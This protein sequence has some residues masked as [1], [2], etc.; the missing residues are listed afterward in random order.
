MAESAQL[1]Q[2]YQEWLQIPE[3]RLPPNHYALLG[4]DDYVDDVESI[5]QAAKERN[6]YLHQLAAGP[7]RKIVQEMLGKIAIAR[8]T[9]INA[10]AKA[11]YDQ[12]LLNPAA[13]VAILESFDYIETEPPP[14]AQDEFQDD[15]QDDAPERPSAAERMAAGRRRRARN[16]WIYHAISASV[17]LA[18]VGVIYL[19]NQGGGRRLV[20][21]QKEST[22]SGSPTSNDSN[23]PKRVAARALTSSDPRPAKARSTRPVKPRKTNSGLGMGLSGDMSQVFA[24]INSANGEGEP[25][26]AKPAESVKPVSRD[27]IDQVKTNMNPG[28]ILGMAKPV[29]SLPKALHGEFSSNQGKDWFKVVEGKVTV[30]HRAEKRYIRLTAKGKPFAFGKIVAVTSS[31]VPGAGGDAQV[32]VMAGGVR[33]GLRARGEQLEVFAKPAKQEVKPVVL[34]SIDKKAIGD[35]ADKATIALV[36]DLKDANRFHWI[37]RIGNSMENGAIAVGGVSGQADTSVFV[38]APSKKLDAAF[39]VKA[40]GLGKLK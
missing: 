32:G 8:R 31:L 1:N 35:K 3:E 27:R 18:I 23:A 19:V 21:Q 12:N 25:E 14:I 36:R 38:T 26:A 5:E 7:Q 24:E 13:E 39:E 20:H 15:A 9:L 33:V 30:P 37:V 29:E 22:S 34:K 16:Q 28:T 6:A 11:D 10:D 4:L 40:I 17:L 2:L